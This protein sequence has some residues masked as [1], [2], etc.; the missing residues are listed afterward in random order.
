MELGRPD[1]AIPWLERAM[2]APRYQSPQFPHINLARIHEERGDLLDAAK[3]F[4]KALERDPDNLPVRHAVRRLQQR[5][6]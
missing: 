5:L 3:E 6:N 2:K 4:S 1:E